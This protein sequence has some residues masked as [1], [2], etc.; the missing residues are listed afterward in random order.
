MRT[1][2][3]IL[4]SWNRFVCDLGA[5]WTCDS[6]GSLDFR[7]YD[8]KGLRLLELIIIFYVIY[9]SVMTKAVV[10]CGNFSYPNSIN[11]R[12]VPPI[13]PRSWTRQ[14]E[15]GHFWMDMYKVTPVPNILLSRWGR[16]LALPQ[17]RLG[18]L[19][20]RNTT[21]RKGFT[22]FIWC[23]PYVFFNSWLEGFSFFDSR[24]WS[25]PDTGLTYDACWPYINI[26]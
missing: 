25:W 14:W 15:R 9:I 20:P 6:D 24:R 18:P 12:K 17:R 23:I 13:S 16:C 8:G 21:G 7:K 10:L 1:V 3:L 2:R 5:I 11:W 19:G 26:S 4:Q 22:Q